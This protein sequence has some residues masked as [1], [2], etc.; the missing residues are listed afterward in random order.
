MKINKADGIREV[1]ENKNNTIMIY[2]IAQKFFYVLFIIYA[3]FLIIFAKMDN[4]IIANLAGLVLVAFFMLYQ[5][6]YTSKTFYINSML[7]IY[8]IFFIF[9]VL[10]LTWSIDL[11]YSSYTIIRM[12]QMFINLLLLYNILKIFKLEN[13]IFI[14]FVIGMLVNVVLATE[15][16]TIANPIYLKVRFIGTTTHPNTIGLLAIFAIIS[17]ILLLQSLKNRVWIVFNL[18]N[19]LGSFYVIIL[20]ASRSSLI[21][22]ALIILLFLVQVLLNPKSRVYLFIF[23]G[24]AFLFFIYFVDLNQL[25]EHAKFA[26]DRIAGIFGTIQGQ[27]ADSSTTERFLFLHIMIGVFKENP[28]FGTGINTSRVFLHGFYSHNNYIEIL[29]ALGI[30]GLMIYYSAY[31]YLLWKISKVKDF[32]TKYY[33]FV[34]IFVI[35][36]Y[37][38]AAVTFYAKVILMMLLVLHYMA[39]EKS[40]IN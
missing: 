2:D 7:V 12:A 32:W 9:C 17:S 30:F 39:E 33:L 24:V 15:L 36:I 38:F 25:M 23:G 14:G 18:I 26:M 27:H 16:I 20:T 19:I 3:A 34:F 13:A 10:S 28:F 1:M 37:D 31:G 29:G 4:E 5:L 21:I 8:F 6:L 40:K 35:I 11:H 22:A